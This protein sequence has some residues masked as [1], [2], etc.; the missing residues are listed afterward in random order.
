M[1]RRRPPSSRRSAR[2]HRRLLGVVEVPDPEG[3]FYGV[4]AEIGELDMTERRIYLHGGAV[5][6][7]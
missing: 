7:H 2:S 1:R 4:D 5:G 6:E 3:G